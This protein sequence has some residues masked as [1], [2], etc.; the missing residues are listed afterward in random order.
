MTPD[1]SISFLPLLFLALTLQPGWHGQYE[2]R[3]RKCPLACASCSPSH[4]QPDPCISQAKAPCARIISL[5]CCS[6]SWAPLQALLY[7]PPAPRPAGLR[8]TERFRWACASCESLSWEQLCGGV[9]QGPAV[10]AQEAAALP[11]TPL[12]RQHLQPI[13]LVWLFSGCIWDV[14]ESWSIRKGHWGGGPDSLCVTL[15]DFFSYS[16]DWWVINLILLWNYRAE[17]TVA[18]LWNFSTVGEF[19]YGW[20]NFSIYA[21]KYSTNTLSPFI[22]PVVTTQMCS[23]KCPDLAV[24]LGRDHLYAVDLQSGT[25]T[26]FSCLSA[27]HGCKGLQSFVI[28]LLIPVGRHPWRTGLSHAQGSE[29]FEDILS[30]TGPCPEE[31]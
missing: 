6:P 13:L 11:P 18:L 25:M 28:S 14:A 24:P 30:C 10:K 27:C 17:I 4:L 8:G 22:L 1:L 7:S 29:A 16:Y 23:F 19:L 21:S 5:Q 3:S 31:F 26:R 9:C 20:W 2:A 12:L 15:V